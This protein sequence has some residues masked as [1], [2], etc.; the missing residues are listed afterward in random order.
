MHSHQARASSRA[1]LNGVHRQNFKVSHHISTPARHCDFTVPDALFRNDMNPLDRPSPSCAVVS[2]AGTLHGSRCASTIDSYEVVLR[3]NLAPTARFAED[4]G[5]RTSMMLLNSHSARRVNR[6]LKGSKDP[7][8]SACYDDNRA[9]VFVGDEWVPAIDN[10][11]QTARDVNHRFGREKAIQLSPAMGLPHGA[12]PKQLDVAL[13]R[14]GINGTHCGPW[15]A[16]HGHS[17]CLVT[18]GFTAVHIAF[19]L[20]RRVGLFGFSPYE[21]RGAPFHYYD[22]PKSVSGAQSKGEMD[23][24]HN[25]D[26]EKAYYEHLEA[27]DT[28]S[29]CH[30]QATRR[31]TMG[32]TLKSARARAWLGE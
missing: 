3:M 28:V 20:C 23:H 30:Q 1:C 10:E 12:I 26:A 4:V 18:S 31:R 16:L 21:R 5:Q 32:M 17:R 2:G 27:Q 7:A 22:A 6:H 13:R 24:S 25:L 11:T 14:A 8:V 15:E 9:L 19:A 29:V